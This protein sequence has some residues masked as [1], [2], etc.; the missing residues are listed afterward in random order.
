[1]S[2]SSE[3]KTELCALPVSDR[4]LALAESY[5]V[6]LY[7]HT[8]T[9]RE[10]R[11]VTASDA[12]AQRLPRVFRKAFNVTLPEPTQN[13]RDRQVFHTE[14]AAVLS[15]VLDAIGLDAGRSVS[16]HINL[17]VLEEPGATVAFLR[18]AFLAGGSVTDPLKGFHFELAT[19]HY[20]VSREAEAILTELGYPPN[21]TQRSG[22]YMLYYKRA[23]VIAD[24][25]TLLGADTSS[26]RV[27]E[28]Q[29]ERSMNNKVNRQINC[30]SANADKVVA[31]A[32]EQ[33]DAILR[34]QS[35]YGLSVL[36]EKLQDAALLRI[37]NPEASLADL[38]K[39]SYPPVSKSTLS[40]RLKKILE[41]DP[42]KG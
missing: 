3:I 32:Q 18:G 30:D 5:G 33:L 28:A 20:S 42:K 16:H 6:L 36:P 12:F 1:M 7:C 2:F 9:P 22:S 31:A 23:E 25:L 37:A 11:I 17:G 10:L 41:F 34:I 8:F 15:P 40:Y 24:L 26:L 13:G 27:I 39:L 4:A 21:S 35:E 38:A 19:A 14:D 29:V